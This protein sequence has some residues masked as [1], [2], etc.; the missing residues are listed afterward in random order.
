MLLLAGTIPYD[1]GQ[2]ITGRVDYKAGSLQVG[3]NQLPVSR[4]TA[5]LI[6][7]AA[8]CCR[9]FKNKRRSYL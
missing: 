3:K 2:I 1:V 8:I 6:S 7:A 5:A 4:G 9:H